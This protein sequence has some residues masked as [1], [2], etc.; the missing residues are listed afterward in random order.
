[1]DCRRGGKGGSRRA[2][3]GRGDSSKSS[4]WETGWNQLPVEVMTFIFSL[5]PAEERLYVLPMVCRLWRS[6]ALRPE[7]FREADLED[8]SE[9]R[10]L[11]ALIEPSN[12]CKSMVRR[13]SADEALKRLGERVGVRHLEVLRARNCSAQGLGYLLP[14]SCKP[15]LL[16]LELP[17]LLGNADLELSR[18]A[19]ASSSSLRKLIIAPFYSESS[20]TGHVITDSF[21]FSLANTCR[22]LTHLDI[23]ECKGVTKWGILAVLER[24][25]NLEALS[26]SGC[27]SEREDMREVLN[28]IAA[29][30]CHKLTSL[31]VSR[32]CVP[33][34]AF[35]HVI[36]KC[37]KLQSLNIS[38]VLVLTP[39]A[40]H[41]IASVTSLGELNLGWN[42]WLEDTHAKLLSVRTTPFTSLDLSGT[43]LSDAGM[44][45][46]A[47]G[48]GRTLVKLRA[49][50][51][52]ISDASIEAIATY[53]SNLERLGALETN[54]SDRAAAIVA[55]SGCTN[56]ISLSLSGCCERVVRDS[57]SG[58]SSSSSS[59][60]A[61]HNECRTLLARC[62]KLIELAMPITDCY[63][64]QEEVV[65]GGGRG[66]A[67]RERER[68]AERERERERDRDRDRR[69]SSYCTHRR[70]S[71]RCRQ[72][73]AT[74][75]FFEA[76]AI[77]SSRLKSLSLT[78]CCARRYADISQA[79]IAF[80][81]LC[82]SVMAVSFSKIFELDDD[83]LRGL[84]S[85]C[86][87]LI[88][89]TLEYNDTVTD[90]GLKALVTACKNLKVVN[91]KQCPE[92]SLSV[93]DQLA[94]LLPK[95][96]V[97]DAREC[98]CTEL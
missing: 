55:C 2:A 53:C 98:V 97:A 62:P 23:T 84:G 22:N 1:M 31:D 83:T 96:T 92:I 12:V 93:L 7:C 75:P 17:D 78:G 26:L 36:D 86:P 54:V 45:A 80:L 15:R 48:L 33:C 71:R 73:I 18:L 41:A 13:T 16:H 56:L 6:I 19:A 70:R 29:N 68:A 60:L 65:G 57:G 44:I 58:S 42:S 72:V 66:G 32:T 20:G 63:G 91:I 34:D 10:V 8:W 25:R 74:V 4:G 24:C 90:V 27:L 5:L 64:A 51:T 81:G 37:R 14:P 52:L 30:C 95:K 43:C 61:P 28:A 9:K 11:V 39:Q 82:T 87:H 47:R 46:V 76:L 3:Q 69:P 50:N 94:K 77:A 89:F 21:L 85:A 59:W 79:L 88:Y 49:H 38:D 40:V 67:V 35:V